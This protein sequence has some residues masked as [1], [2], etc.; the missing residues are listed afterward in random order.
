[1]STPRRA[2]SRAT[3]RLHGLMYGKIELAWGDTDKTEPRIE[4]KS[5]CLCSKTKK[6]S[7]YFIVS[8]ETEEARE[9][10]IHDVY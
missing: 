8:R 6:P 5:R 3:A 10:Q 4:P 9:S 1:M 7:G 2:K